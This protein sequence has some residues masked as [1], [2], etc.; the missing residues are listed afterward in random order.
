MMRVLIACETSG[1]VRDA[2]IARGHQALSCDLL[3]SDAPGPHYQG[4]VREVWHACWDLMIAHPDCTHLSVSG[5]LHFE[6]KWRDGRQARA[7]AFFMELVRAPVQRICIENPVSIMSTLYC[8]PT[9]I[10][11]PY[12]FGEDASKA[13]CLWLKGLPLLVVDPRK[14][15][16]GR[17][18]QLGG[19]LVER[20]S[21]QCDSGQNKLGPSEY[22]WKLRAATYQGIADAMAEQWSSAPQQRLAV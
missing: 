15:I 20:W 7:A 12:E 16:P 5:A 1:K 8:R 22:R 17:K 21:N 10:V 14:R 6:K 3:P 9:Q 2:F 18:V 19:R 4:D 13:T 11:Q